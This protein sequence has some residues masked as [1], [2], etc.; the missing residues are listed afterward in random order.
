M[1]EISQQH[2]HTY[3][4][5]LVLFVACDRKLNIFRF[6]NADLHNIKKRH[7]R[8]WVCHFLSLYLTL[9]DPVMCHN[10]F[11]LRLQAI[12]ETSDMQLTLNE[13]Y[14][15][16]T[17]TFA[18]FRRNAATWKVANLQIINSAMPYSVSYQISAACFQWYLLHSDFLGLERSAPQP[19]SAQVFC[20]RGEC[21][22]RRVDGGWGG[23]P[24]EE[25]PEDHRVEYSKLTI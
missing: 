18:Y 10:F 6:W 4:Y 5:L 17:R 22:R 23:I 15:W 16:F 1:T 8:V 7:I 14:N 21:E 9:F 2:F 11:P 12:M 24:E 20:A 25:I 3:E 19:Q 13:I